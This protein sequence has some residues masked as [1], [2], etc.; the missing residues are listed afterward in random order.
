M[1]GTSGDDVMYLHSLMTAQIGALP[2]WLQMPDWFWHVGRLFEHIVRV[3]P[4]LWL[5]LVIFAEELGIPL[6]VPGDAAI[7]Y[8]GY[9]TTT[10]VL[11]TP[12]AYL[13]VISAATIGSFC[14]YSIC[15]RFGHP[16]LVRFG[17]YV[18]LTAE[19]L[20]AAE[21]AFRRWGPWA[22]I[23]GRHIPG[24]RIVLSAF[25]GVFELPRR[26]FVPCVLISS[27]VWAAIFLELGRMLGRNSRL[28][29][30]MI[31]VH[32]LPLVFVLLA[33][34]WAVWL[35]YEHR[36]RPR[37]EARRRAARLAADRV[38]SNSTLPPKAEG[39]TAKM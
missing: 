4:G 7:M 16:F 33:L 25:A 11:P 13:A 26:V 10:G 29:F 5:F 24:M 22:V 21:A 36:W 23:I 2:A 35:L 14:N 34:V 38:Q 6:P 28:L 17:P 39:R 20:D 32:L 19:R 31:P 1:A 27:T 3:Q 18:G 12:L 37:R 9:L 30:R 15:R 8:G